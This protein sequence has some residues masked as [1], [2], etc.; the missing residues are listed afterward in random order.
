[1][2]ATLT[3]DISNPNL[4]NHQPMNPLLA[5]PDLK[6]RINAPEP[7]SPRANRGGPTVSDSAEC[8]A[9]PPGPNPAGPPAVKSVAARPPNWFA[10]TH[11]SVVLAAAESHLPEGG[12]ALEKLCRTYWK[13][14][15]AFARNLGHSEHDAQDLTQ[16]FFEHFL[17][18]GYIRAADPRRGRFR[19]FLLTSFHHFTASE[20]A[21]A[22]AAKRG[23]S[24]A[25]VSLE[26][27]PAD[28]DFHFEHPAGLGP[29]AV[30]DRQWA[31]RV[32]D[33]ALSRLRD[34]FATAGKREQF[35]Q[36]KPFLSRLGTGADYRCVADKCGISEGAIAVAVCRLRVRYGEL[37]RAEIANTVASPDDIEDELELLRQFLIA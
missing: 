15:F 24:V 37:L 29:E 11:W 35:S 22:H 13:P 28:A 7:D 32:F 18:R 25:F 5:L 8:S 36:L 10:S 23:G 30:Y 3:M 34:E 9:T 31:L 17:A 20:W 21:K 12:T 33:L 19:S 27:L 4:S 1:A 16:G 6:V 26:E 2:S 14:L